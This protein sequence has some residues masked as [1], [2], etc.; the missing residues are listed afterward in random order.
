MDGQTET[1]PPGEQLEAL[2][3][4]AGLTQSALGARVGG[5]SQSLVSQ[6]ESGK[7]T[8]TLT[9]ALALQGV[10]GLDARVWGYS[11]AQVARVRAAFAPDDLAAANATPAPA[12]VAEHPGAA[13]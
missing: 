1:A 9:D 11:D 8:P 12:D 13:A 6:W 2:R 10:L 7:K 3:D 4:A 5:S